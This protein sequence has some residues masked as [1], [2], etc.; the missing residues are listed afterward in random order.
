MRSTECHSSLWRN[1]LLREAH[2][3]NVNLLIV[4]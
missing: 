2:E 4:N 1:Q 3:K